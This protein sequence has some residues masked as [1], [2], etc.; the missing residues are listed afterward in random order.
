MKSIVFNKD[1]TEGMKEFEDN[2]FD[3][4]VVDL[5]YNIGASK[6][7]VKPDFVK[8]KNGKKIRV[9]QP[10]YLQK[11]WDSKFSDQEYFDELFRV[12]KNQIIFGGNYYGLSG[13]YL[14]WDKLN[15]ESDQFGCEMAWLSFSQRTDIVYYMWSGMFQGVYCGKDISRALV[16]QGNKSLNEKRIHPT[17]KPVI[18]YDWIYKTYLPLGGKVLDT[19]LG[20]GSNRI[21]ADKAGNIDFIGFEIDLDYYKDQELRYNNH[22][23]QLTIF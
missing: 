3:L 2:F 11:D 6:P 9:K 12:S 17:Q 21:S 4:A 13:G 19:H 23:S 5:E 22:K 7:S 18:L 16:Q 20:S 14:V 10:N 15:K 8:Q 1:H